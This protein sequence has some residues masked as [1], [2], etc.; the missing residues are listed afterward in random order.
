MNDFDSLEVYILQFENNIEFN[1]DL[2]QNSFNGSKN[3]FDYRIKSANERAQQLFALFTNRNY[4]KKEFM[5]I[6]TKESQSFLACVSNL[7][8]HKNVFTTLLK[9]FMN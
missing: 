1:L 7:S 4:N 3:M 5:K 8:K 6:C 2:I 9:S